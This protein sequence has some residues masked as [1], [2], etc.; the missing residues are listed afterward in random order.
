[1]HP[2]FAFLAAVGVVSG[3]STLLAVLMVIADSTIARYGEVNITVNDEKE[4]LVEGGRSLLSTL[5][6]SGLFIPSACGGRGSCGLCKVKVTDGAGNV[7]PT[8]LPWLSE[9]EQQSSIRLAC[10]LKVKH[11]TSINIP[12]ELFNVR[13]FETEVV[14]IRNLTYDIK[15]VTLRLD[16]PDKM[17]FKAGQFIQFEVPGYELADEPVYRA[18]SV[19]S[20]PS[21]DKN[22]ELEIRLVPNGI[23]TTYVHKYL[24]V[25]ERVTINGP[26]GDFRLSGTDSDILFVAGGSGMAPIKSILNDMAEKGISRKTRYFFGGRSL[27]DLFLL[28][29][30]ADLEARLPE[31]RFIPA[32]SEPQPDDNWT[33]EVG[34]VT[35][36][37][38][39]YVESVDDTEAYLCR[40]P[41]MIDACK[42]MLTAKGMPEELIYHDEFA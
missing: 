18:Y 4:Y 13:Q 30:M 16:E 39:R 3:V 26:Y 32:L 12:E 31:F 5:Q 21:R 38:D 19:S 27:S 29:D 24:K 40:S 33:G 36:V 7:L 37:V 23:C 25:G 15:E 35:E 10:Q 42:E 14:S 9:D 8:E 34:L 6:E 20:P 22:I 2:V 11:D 28:D 17:D 1:M 41:G